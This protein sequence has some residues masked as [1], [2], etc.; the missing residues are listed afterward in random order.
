MGELKAERDH[1]KTKLYVSIELATKIISSVALVA[2]GVAGW[3][4]QSQSE[5]TRSLA[6]QFELQ[7]RK[8]LPMLRSLTM[9]ELELERVAAWEPAS[10]NTK[11]IAA[12]SVQNKQ[13]SRRAR[14]ANLRMKFLGASL[15]LPDGDQDI[16][17]TSYKNEDLES[18]PWPEDLAI[19]DAPVKLSL[20]AA[21]FMYADLFRLQSFVIE[22]KGSYKFPMVLYPDGRYLVET[23]EG[24]P[25][26]FDL[27]PEAAPAWKV[28]LSDAKLDDSYLR[29]DADMIRLAARLRYA[30]GE[31][32]RTVLSQHPDLGD[33]YVQ[34]R[35]E[36]ER[37]RVPTY[38]E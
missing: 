31:A 20:R 12:A 26:Y 5:K 8:Y 34:I 38:A 3:M 13:R 29:N 18:M 36:L 25:N 11:S 32:T 19:D 2:L 27:S 33:R 35:D 15:Y 22:S 30:V 1:T 23:S 21:A 6:Q 28:W 17:I 16:S 14:E 10:P 7:E 37:R 4:L 24:Y 9:L